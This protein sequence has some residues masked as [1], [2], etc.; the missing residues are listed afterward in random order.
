MWAWTPL[1][2]ATRE[3]QQGSHDLSQRTEQQASTLEETASAMEHLRAWSLAARKM[4]SPP[5]SALP[6]S[7]TMPSAAA[8]S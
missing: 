5:A 8:R 4:L 3:I 2:E 1:A 6:R 7:A